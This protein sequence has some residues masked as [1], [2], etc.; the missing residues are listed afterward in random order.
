MRRAMGAWVGQ[1]GLLLAAQRRQQVCWR[2]PT[3]SGGG[4]ATHRENVLVCD[5]TARANHHELRGLKICTGAAHRP[6]VR[7]AL[8]GDQD[9]ADVCQHRCRLQGGGPGRRRGGVG[10]GAGADWR[11]IAPHALALSWL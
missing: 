6:D 4:R 8:G 10:P 11:A 5:V 2:L 1:Q 3:R 7:H 9:Y